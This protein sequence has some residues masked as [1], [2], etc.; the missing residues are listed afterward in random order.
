MKANVGNIDRGI[1]LIIG[2][3]ALAAIFVGP[4]AGGG[5]QSIAAGVIGIIM[6]GTSAIKFCPLYRIFGMRTC[7]I[8]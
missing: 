4:F 1:R 8:D 5:W 3:V 2:I 6:I 7:S